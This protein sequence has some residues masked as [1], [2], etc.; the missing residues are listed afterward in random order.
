MATDVAFVVVHV[1]VKDWPGA[2]LDALALNEETVGVKATARLPLAP[3][4][5]QPGPV[6]V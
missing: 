4:K 3:P 5:A 6:F 2:T 1:R